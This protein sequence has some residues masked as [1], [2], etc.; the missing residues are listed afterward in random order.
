MTSSAQPYFSMIAAAAQRY[1]LTA[2]DF[3]AVT[4][5]A[6]IEDL[7]FIS[8]VEVV[9]LHSSAGPHY[10]DLLPDF[11]GG[12]PVDAP[13][14]E[15]EVSPSNQTPAAA[16]GATDRRFS[17]LPAISASRVDIAFCSETWLAAG[18]T[19]FKPSSDILVIVYGYPSRFTG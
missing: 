15:L 2:A 19:Y 14:A 10:L 3:D 6:S 9:Y 12:T 8:G 5:E 17:W 18:R 11:A 1:V 16:T 7:R 13:L 4:F